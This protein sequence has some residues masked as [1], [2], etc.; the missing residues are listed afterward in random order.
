MKSFVSPATRFVAVLENA[1]KRPS[2]EMV[3]RNDALFASSPPVLS[4]RNE[5]QHARARPV[6]QRIEDE[7][8]AVAGHD[9][10]FVHARGI[11]CV[12]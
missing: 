1:T 6:D 12:Q 2:A 5:A 11:K 10:A 4:V 8:F 3:D 7:F 9:Q